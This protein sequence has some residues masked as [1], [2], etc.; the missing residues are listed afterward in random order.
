MKR[1]L[2]TTCVWVVVFVLSLSTASQAFAMD[3][4]GSVSGVGGV[5]LPSYQQG[6]THTIV[7]DTSSFDQSYSYYLKVRAGGMGDDEAQTENFSIATS[8]TYS[9]SDSTVIVDAPNN[10]L[11]WIIASSEALQ[12]SPLSTVEDKHYVNVYRHQGGFLVSNEYC[13]AG[14]YTTRKDVL[15]NSKC[16]LVVWQGDENVAP[17]APNAACYAPG[18]LTNDSKINL[19][20]DGLTVE[21]QPYNGVIVFAMGAEGWDIVQDQPATVTNGIGMTSF[22]PQSAAKHSVVVKV[23]RLGKDYVVPNCSGN[24]QVSDRCNSCNHTRQSIN[25]G[26]DGAPYKICDQIDSN[27]TDSQGRSLKDLCIKCTGNNDDQQ[28]GIWTALGCIPREPEQIVK[29]LLLLGLGMGGGAALIMILVAGFQIT[30]S[31]GSPEKFNKAKE[32]LVGAITGLL[33]I[34]FSVTILQF[35]GYSILKIPG[36]G[37]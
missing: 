15:R 30:I 3:C 5:L 19:R 17:P 28:K 35:I 16:Q 4:P 32:M 14:Y 8:R 29:R 7:F 26:A 37:G 6:M 20:V 13:R 9:F 24:F 21:N 12:S 27:L 11:T 36:F 23:S 33:F 22:T 1:L 34:I 25:N 2:V 31:Q 10:K 18:C